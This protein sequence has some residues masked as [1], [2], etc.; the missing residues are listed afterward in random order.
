[1]TRRPISIYASIADRLRNIARAKQADLQLIMRRYAIERLLYRQ[2]GTFGHRSAPA[3]KFP[4][5]S[6]SSNQR[7]LANVNIRLGP[8]H[9]ECGFA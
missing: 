9:A 3:A 4:S 5:G 1:M 7:S 8:T 2:S 6:I